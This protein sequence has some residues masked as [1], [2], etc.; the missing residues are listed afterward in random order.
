[1]AYQH[2]PRSE[3]LLARRR[4]FGISGPHRSDLI[5][6]VPRNSRCWAQLLVHA[7]DREVARALD[8]ETMLPNEKA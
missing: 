6:T 7:D 3:A 2:V 4:A 8:S 5:H 1:M